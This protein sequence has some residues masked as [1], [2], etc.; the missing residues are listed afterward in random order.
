M[1][2]TSVPAILIS[3]VLFT[4]LGLAGVGEGVPFDRAS[5]QAAPPASSTSPA[6]PPADGRP[7]HP[8]AAPAPPFAAI[9]TSALSPA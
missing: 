7:D 4:I 3:A 9:L 8:V 1:V 2:W 6:E 5:A